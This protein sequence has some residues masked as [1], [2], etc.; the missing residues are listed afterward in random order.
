MGCSQRLGIEVRIEE[1]VGALVVAGVGAEQEEGEVT[2][3]SKSLD[4]EAALQGRS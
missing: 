2:S 3:S 4:W 1:G